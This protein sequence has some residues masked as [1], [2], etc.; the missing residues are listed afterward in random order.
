MDALD[1]V[2]WLDAPDGVLLDRVQARGH[3]YLDTTSSREQRDQFLARYREAFAKTFEQEAA[4]GPKILRF[5]SDQRSVGEIASD[6]LD[7]LA[8]EH[9]RALRH[10]GSY[11]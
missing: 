7:A 1:L 6:V 2:V 10:G 3:R 5:R 8:S 9:T 4:D 11:T